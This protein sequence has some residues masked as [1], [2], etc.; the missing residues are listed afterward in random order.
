MSKE[1]ESRNRAMAQMH[2]EG[3]TVQVIADMY[4]ITRQAVSKI[5][6]RY[7]LD[8]T[9]TD[10][11]TRSISVA[12]IEA[13]EQEM[14]AIAFSPPAVA[15]DVKG[16]ILRDDLGNPVLNEASYKHKFDAADMFRKLNDAKARRTALD[17][18][19]RKQIDADEA[20]RQAEEWLASLPRAELE[21]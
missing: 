20:R 11:E 21:D 3:K 18:P 6:A 14:F 12:Q 5:I 1:L 7:A 8:A 19:R 16:Q 15:F 17:L 2:M 4:G 10:D 13:L 9:V